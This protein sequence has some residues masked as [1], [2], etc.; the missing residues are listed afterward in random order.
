[1]TKKN[2]FFESWSLLKFNNLELALYMALKLYTSLAKKVKTKS[3]KVFGAKFNVCRSYSGKTGREALKRVK[4][5]VLLS[6]KK[7]SQAS[8]ITVKTIKESPDLIAYFILHK[9]TTLCQV[10][11]TQLV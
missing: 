10:L 7:A 9:F 5:L 8:D 6:G 4:E 2:N 3:Q 1:M 11:N